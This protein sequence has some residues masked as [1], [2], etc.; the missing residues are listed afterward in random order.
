M[1]L[2]RHNQGG[3]AVFAPVKRGGSR[4]YFTALGVGYNKEVLDTNEYKEYL[5]IYNIK[6]EDKDSNFTL[7]YLRNN[8]K[9][10]LNPELLN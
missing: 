2:L 7:I 3:T 6:N 1:W 4:F 9:I 5:L 10:K 8:R